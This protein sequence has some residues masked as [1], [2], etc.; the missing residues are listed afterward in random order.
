VRRPAAYPYR[1][2]FIEQFNAAIVRMQASGAIRRIV[3]H[4]LLP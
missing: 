2:D 4:A 3:D 1:D